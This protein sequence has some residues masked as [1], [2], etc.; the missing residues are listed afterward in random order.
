M[1][2]RS[3]IIDFC[4]SHLTRG[5][6]IEI[7]RSLLIWNFSKVAP[8]TRCVDWN[9]NVP[10]IFVSTVW[11]HLTRGAWIEIAKYIG[12]DVNYVVAPHTRC[13]DWNINTTELNI[14]LL[15]R[16]SHE[17]RGLKYLRSC[18]NENCKESHL[19]R[20][21]WIEICVS[22]QQSKAVESHLTRGVWEEFWCVNEPIS[23]FAS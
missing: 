20:G 21:A 16:T 13:V 3:I 7:F 8:H 4:S 10:A 2:Y 19:T 17:V 15:G 6:W 22:T 9:I 12:V 11:S 1:K 5:A 23:W 14:F 18:K